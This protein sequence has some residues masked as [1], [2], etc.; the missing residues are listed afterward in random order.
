[1]KYIGNISWEHVFE[2]WRQREADNPGWIRCATEIKGWSDWESW[3]KYSARQ[4]QADQREWRLYAFENPSQE[5]PAM[6]L[7]PYTGWQ[8]RVPKKNVATFEDLLNIPEQFDAFRKQKGILS[9]MESLPF[10][11]QF[12]GV[13]HDGAQQIVCLD[14]HHRATAIALAKKLD[15]KIDFSGVSVTIALTR[16][17]PDE[18]NVFDEVLA[19]GTSKPSEA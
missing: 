5:I 18:A 6:L 12:I 19:R 17:S 9:M 3:R 14:G 15:K 13:I 2:G 7:G 16:F 8:S 1:M 10:S 4:I 11:T